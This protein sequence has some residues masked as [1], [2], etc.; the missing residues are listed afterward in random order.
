M[1]RHEAEKRESLNAA[2]AVCAQQFAESRD[3]DTI[4][5]NAVRIIRHEIGLDRAGIFL[6]DHEARLWRGVFG[7]D[8]NGAIRDEH[9]LNMPQDP[10]HPMN[11]A[12]RGEGN[13]FFYEDFSAA[14]PGDTFMAEVKNC[15]FITLRA[16][17]HL[18]GGVSVDNL[19][20]GRLID[21]ET[22]EDLRQFTRYMALALE[23]L[24]LL[25][26]LEGANRQLERANKDLTEFADVMAHDLTSPMQ[27][28]TLLLELVIRQYEKELPPAA[29]ESLQKAL[30]RVLKLGR[31][32]QGILRYSRMGKR[33]G[34]PVLLDVRQ[35][36][37]EVLEMLQVPPGIVISVNDD[38]PELI[39]DQAQLHQVFQNLIANAIKY[40]GRDEGRIQVT[41]EKRADAWV[42]CVRDTGMGISEQYHQN[43]FKMFNRAG[44]Q[45]DGKS[46][47]LG[48]AL[49]KKII[50]RGGGEIWLESKEGE[51]CAFFFT[52]PAQGAA[53][54]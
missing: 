51:G 16:H 19:E 8:L 30:E 14:F 47:G 27:G 28:V 45:D 7:T 20:T 11:R 18:L 24:E 48:L 2:I 43:L 25:N 3:L 26:R 42:F 52:V 9:Q 34:E 1:E 4:L 22:R 23:N 21:E 40:M 13:E 35:V 6:Y 5:E 31:F 37:N 10:R 32:L 41:C 46:C 39:Y 15:F 29:L 53:L 54:R 17:E 12:E 33:S 44:R 36:V 38:L 50:E 49:V